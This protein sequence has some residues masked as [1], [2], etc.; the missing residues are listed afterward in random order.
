MNKK[1]MRKES[2]VCRR[3]SVAEMENWTRVGSPA[4]QAKALKGVRESSEFGALCRE[5][6]R[7]VAGDAIG[8]LNSA[9]TAELTKRL[10]KLHAGREDLESIKVEHPDWFR[11]NRTYV[12]RTSP[13]PLVE[14]GR[15]FDFDA[16]E[17]FRRFGGPGSWVR[18]QEDGTIVI[19]DV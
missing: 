4:E 6:L 14:P 19:P 8:L 17:I 16:E 9:S 18:W 11:G 13:P 10:N 2:C 15:D 1:T 7:K 3:S 12:W 5:H